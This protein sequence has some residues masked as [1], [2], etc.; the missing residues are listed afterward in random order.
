MTTDADPA[1]PAWAASAGGDISPT[2]AAIRVRLG[3]TAAEHRT[4]RLGG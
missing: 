2:V 1:T 3:D 4:T